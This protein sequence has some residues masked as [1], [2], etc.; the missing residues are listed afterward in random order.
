MQ[1]LLVPYPISLSRANRVPGTVRVDWGHKKPHR[2]IYCTLM[3][4]PSSNCIPGALRKRRLRLAKFRAFRVET[5]RAHRGVLAR[6]AETD[7]Q[8]RVHRQRCEG[9]CSGAGRA[10]PA[11]REC[12]GGVAPVMARSA[13]CRITRR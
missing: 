3:L 6:E 1:F 8:D 2:H 12:K 7:A 4:Q 10:D 11:T 13:L 9:S 5:R